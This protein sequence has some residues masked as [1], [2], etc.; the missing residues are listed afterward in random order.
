MDLKNQFTEYKRVYDVYFNEFNTLKDSL[1]NVEKN[2]IEQDKKDIEKQSESKDK[3]EMLAEYMF[4]Q[5]KMQLIL[6]DM[7]KISERLCFI[8]ESAVR[9]STDLELSEENK[10]FLKNLVQ[11]NS[12][13]YVIDNNKLASKVEGLDDIIRKKVG[14]DKEKQYLHLDMIRNK[15]GTGRG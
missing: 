1:E 8:N 11:Y 14:E 15:N 6:N 10:T 7:S 5:Y 4:L 3:F 9:T 12:S 13:S 2:I